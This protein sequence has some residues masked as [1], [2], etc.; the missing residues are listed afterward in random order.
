MTYA[1]LTG[2]EINLGTA[3]QVLSLDFNIA[4]RPCWQNDLNKHTDCRDARHLHDTPRARQ[5]RP[6]RLR[7]LFP[8]ASFP[9]ASFPWPLADKNQSRRLQGDLSLGSV[10]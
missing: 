7:I 6:A 2:V 4:S 5:N 1:S 3:Q 8:L 9:F 10:A